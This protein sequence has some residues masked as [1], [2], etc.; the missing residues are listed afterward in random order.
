MKRET[1]L[2][3]HAQIDWSITDGILTITI[4]GMEIKHNIEHGITVENCNL[5][6][7]IINKIKGQILAGNLIAK[8]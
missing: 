1:K 5:A 2:R 7:K 6:I 8:P 4:N 3:N